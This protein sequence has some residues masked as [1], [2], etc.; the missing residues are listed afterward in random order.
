MAEKDF[1]ASDI[2]DKYKNLIKEKEI[3]E[4]ELEKVYIEIDFKQRDVLNTEIIQKSLKSFTEIIENTSLENQKELMQLLIK[5]IRVSPFDPQKEKPPKELEAISLKIRNKWIKTEIDLYEISVPS[6]TYDEVNKKFVFSSKWL[7]DRCTQR[8]GISI[9]L[10]MPIH[11]KFDSSRQL[12]IIE[13]NAPYKI[14]TTGRITKLILKQFGPQKIKPNPIKIAKEYELVYKALPS[15][16]MANVAKQFGV[17]RVRVWQMLNLLKLD[18]RIIDHLEN[19][20]DPKVNNFW[21]ERKL[22]PLLGLSKENQFDHFKGYH[23]M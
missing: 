6:T 5:E 12:Q 21:T 3:I 13:G 23:N 14:S 10:H 16:S 7:P 19:I 15:P 20:T 11:V 2:K 9:K 4:Q 22:R 1:V 17:T 8:T 18:S